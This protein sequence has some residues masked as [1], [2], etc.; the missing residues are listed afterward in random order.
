MGSWNFEVD[1]LVRILPSMSYLADGAGDED[2]AK[3][4]AAR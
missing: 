2:A 1:L 3:K 4:E